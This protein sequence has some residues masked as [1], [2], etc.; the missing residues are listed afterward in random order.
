MP[1]LAANLKTV[2]NFSDSAIDEANAALREI[3][4]DVCLSHSCIVCYDCAFLAASVHGLRIVSYLANTTPSFI[5][6]PRFFTKNI[7]HTKFSRTS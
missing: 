1:D 4:L 6:I 7:M 3:N 2:Q 5:R